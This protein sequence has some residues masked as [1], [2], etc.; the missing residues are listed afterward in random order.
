MG[1][2]QCGVEFSRNE[3]ETSDFDQIAVF[4]SNTLLNRAVHLERVNMCTTSMPWVI[5]W[6]IMPL[7]KSRNKR[8]ER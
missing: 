7:E 1:V 5:H 6:S 3:L 4:E 8:K 2:D